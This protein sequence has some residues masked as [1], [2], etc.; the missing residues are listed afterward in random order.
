[1]IMGWLLIIVIVALLFIALSEPKNEVEILRNFGMCPPHKWRWE[2]I[3]DK[4]GKV[5]SHKMAC[6]RCGPL[7]PL[8]K[9]EE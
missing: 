7:Q 1:M 2:E 6:L 5:V 3:L 8:N 4:E 9:D